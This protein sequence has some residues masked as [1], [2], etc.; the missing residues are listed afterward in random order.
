MLQNAIT[1][2]APSKR[3]ANGGSTSSTTDM[4]KCGSPT[5]NMEP[6]DAP[7]KSKSTQKQSSLNM[8]EIL[9]GMAHEINLIAK[10]LKSGVKVDPMTLHRCWADLVI[11]RKRLTAS[12]QSV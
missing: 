6:K 5:G 7:S 8:N 10:E 9:S 4:P 12:N 1:T 2:N 11:C 3:T